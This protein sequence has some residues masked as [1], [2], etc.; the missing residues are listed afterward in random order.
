LHD[1]LDVEQIDQV[2]RQ[3]KYAKSGFVWIG[4]GRTDWIAGNW[5]NLTGTDTANWFGSNNGRDAT[6]DST[7]DLVYIGLNN[8][9]FN[10]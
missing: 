9:N 4:N 7:N 1:V 6:Y 3:K 2:G 5:Y 10:F 8:L